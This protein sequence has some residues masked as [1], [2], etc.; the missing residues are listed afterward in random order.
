MWCR[1][2]CWKAR[3]HW[4]IRVQTSPYPL[5]CK[6]V[7]LHKGE[8]FSQSVAKA[9][10]VIGWKAVRVLGFG[11]SENMPAAMEEFS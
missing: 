7:Q 1:K 6:Y 2:V 9:L 4:C 5:L 10:P 8:S 3:S 11:L